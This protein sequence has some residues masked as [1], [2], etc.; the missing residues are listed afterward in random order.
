MIIVLAAVSVQAQN[1]GT[2]PY[3]LSTHIY[4][5]TKGMTNS[6][7]VWTVLDHNGDVLG[8]P[9]DHFALGTNGSESISITWPKANDATIP[10]Y[11]VQ[12]TETRNATSGYTGC[13][14]IRRIPV[15]VEV[16]AFDVIAELVTP[17][18][19]CATLTDNP[20]VDENANGSNGDDIFGTTTR[21][22]KVKM[23]GG[24]AAKD[25]SFEYLLTDIATDFNLG[26]VTSI[27][28]SAGGTSTA[29]S[30][31]K[32][33]VTVDAATVLKDAGVPY[34]TL[35]ISYNTNKNTFAPITTGQDPDV[36]LVLAISDAKDVL[37]TPDSVTDD[38]SNKATHTVYAVPAT[39]GI[40]TD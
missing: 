36:T 12:V 1:T 31:G 35:D 2:Q 27:T 15:T 6:D 29:G 13:P 22:F 40:I 33:K 14:T 7:L 28:L 38:A 19:E 10:N 17:A 24:D 4:T 20:V 34:I 5:I 9:A 11:I 37:G 25:W 3:V 21:Q 8:T 23:T 32:T 16:N 18:T 26:G 30:G 39:T